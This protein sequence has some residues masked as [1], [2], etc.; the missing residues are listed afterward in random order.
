M[1]RLK[2]LVLELPA[3]HPLRKALETENDTIPKKE[4]LIKSKI[5]DKLAEIPP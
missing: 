2:K 3:E 1:R 5:W 4:F